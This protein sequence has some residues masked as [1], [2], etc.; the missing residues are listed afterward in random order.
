MAAKKAPKRK[1]D[2]IYYEATDPDE[3]LAWVLAHEE[4]SNCWDSEFQ[5]PSKSSA[6]VTTEENDSDEEE[7]S[8]VSSSLSQR[9]VVSPTSPISSASPNSNSDSETGDSGL[10]S[11]DPWATYQVNGHRCFDEWE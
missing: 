11:R 3:K 1:V 9:S 10:G 6:S 8:S 7:A 5:K 4:S 2:P